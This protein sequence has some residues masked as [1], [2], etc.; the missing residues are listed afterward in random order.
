MI[1]GYM[2]VIFFLILSEDKD[3]FPTFK[4]MIKELFNL[5]DL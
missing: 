3:Q 4:N 5:L 1:W 2:R